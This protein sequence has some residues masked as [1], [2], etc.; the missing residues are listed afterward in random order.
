MTEQMH[1][2][3]QHANQMGYSYAWISEFREKHKSSDGVFDDDLLFHLTPREDDAPLDDPDYQIPAPNNVNVVPV[4][5]ADVEIR[6]VD[7]LWTHVLVNGAVNSIQGIAGIG[8]TFLLCAIAAAVTSGGVVQSVD[9]GTERI[10]QGNV[11]YLS[12]DD[13]PATTII[14]RAD[15]LGADLSRLYFQP[16]DTY[17]AIGS[18]ELD[19]LCV[20]IK[21]SLL[22]LDTLQHFIPGKVDYNSANSMTN[23]LQPLKTLAE[24]HNMTVVVIQHVSKMA[25]SGNGGFSVN[26]G[27]GSSAINGIFRSVWTLGRLK[28]DDGKPSAIRA[29]APS[30]TNLV[31]GDPPCM[32]FELSVEKGFLWAGVDHELTAES[33]YDAVKTRTRRAAPARDEAETFLREMLTNGKMLKQDLETQAMLRGISQKTLRDARENIGIVAAQGKGD[34]RRSYWSLPILTADI[35][36]GQTRAT[37][38]NHNCISDSLTMFDY[39]RPLPMRGQP[40]GQPATEVSEESWEVTL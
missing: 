18:A 33:L 37:K 10:T 31:P 15:A 35:G 9:G 7:W 30:K 36:K 6:P 1:P 13:D 2:G 26:F 24:R 32:L 19:S 29:L 27:I 21:P 22:I 4:C 34:D 12:G 8:K 38:G 23:A 16:D 5:A 39:E 25:A 17:P 11:L 28:D 14:P 40:E 3:I 20:F